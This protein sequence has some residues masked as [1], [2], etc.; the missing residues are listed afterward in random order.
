[1]VYHFLEPIQ[2]RGEAELMKNSRGRYKPCG[3]VSNQILLRLEQ[4]ISTRHPSP[5][6]HY[7]YFFQSTVL[8]LFFE[9]FYWPQTSYI[10]SY[11]CVYCY[12]NKR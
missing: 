4:F 6:F 11:L 8:L 1:M 3:N 12:R 2:V 10:M 5:H 9:N 7:F